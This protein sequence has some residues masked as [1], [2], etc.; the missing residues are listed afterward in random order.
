MIDSAIQR[1]ADQV[2]KILISASSD[3]ETG[4]HHIPDVPDVPEGPVG[5]ILSV[6]RKLKDIVPSAD[7]FY[8][9]PVDAPSPPH[10]LVDRLGANNGCA[11]ARTKNQRHP[12]FAY[13]SCAVVSALEAPDIDEARAPSLQWLARQCQA[14]EVMWPDESNFMNINT[15][16]DLAAHNCR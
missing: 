15:P 6:T 1:F 11:V 8:T 16:A 4:L 9:V 3:F 13:W 5:A 14:V 10:D 12:T 2:D 7:G